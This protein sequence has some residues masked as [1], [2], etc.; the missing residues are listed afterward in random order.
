M[1]EKQ[2]RKG[3]ETEGDDQPGA[4]GCLARTGLPLLPLSRLKAQV[5]RFL[6]LGLEA[7]AGFGV[8]LLQ[9]R[10]N[11]VYLV[12]VCSSGRSRSGTNR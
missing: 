12:L 7:D 1:A 8:E 2:L 5:H 10:L 11:G 4:A 3:T 9:G 6:L